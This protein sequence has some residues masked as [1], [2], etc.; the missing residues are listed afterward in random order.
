MLLLIIRESSN[1]EN[2]ETL[3]MSI[4]SWLLDNFLNL[5]RNLL[6]IPITRAALNI[7]DTSDH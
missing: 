1:H 5:T 6:K 4:R 3:L 7:V 2:L